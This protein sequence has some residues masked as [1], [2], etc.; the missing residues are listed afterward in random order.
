MLSAAIMSATQILQPPQAPPAS[1]KREESLR[2]PRIV[3]L[4]AAKGI[5]ILAV[6]IGH[7]LAGIIDSPVG[8]GLEAFRL[9][10]TGIY[11]FHMPLFFLLSGLLVRR[12]LARS[13][14]GFGIDLIL[15]VLWPYLLWSI[16]Q[17]CVIYLA[18]SSVNAPAGRFWPPILKLPVVAPAQFWFLYV[19]FFLHLAALLVVPRL[20]A[21]ALLLVAWVLKLADPWLATTFMF[22]I[23]MVHGGFYALGA[24]AGTEGIS[25]MLGRLGNAV[26]AA[27]IV[28]AIVAVALGTAAILSEQQPGFVRL[29]SFDMTA[30]AWRI[31]YLPA[32]LLGIVAVLIVADSARGAAARALA[33]LGERSMAIFVLHVLFMATFRIVLLKLHVREPM[34]LLFACSLIG[35]AGPLAALAVARRFTNSRLLGLG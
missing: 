33:F 18:G 31:A 19:L 16:V 35:L 28:A 3:W 14:T 5:G 26:R 32:A 4:D 29:S 1:P 12:R 25:A 34:V 20:G 10:Y 17:L 27:L 30:I 8:R 24:W 23:A 7:A 22:H 13:Q 2:K 6:V 9:L 15:S 11:L 21:L